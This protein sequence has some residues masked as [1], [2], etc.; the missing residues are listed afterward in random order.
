MKKDVG[1]ETTVNEVGKSTWQWIVGKMPF[2]GVVPLCTTTASH[3]KVN[4]AEVEGS[5]RH[6][7]CSSAVS[8][9]LFSVC[10]LWSLKPDSWVAFS[11]CFP[12]KHVPVIYLGKRT[13]LQLHL[14]SHVMGC[15]I[16]ASTELNF[17]P[18]HGVACIAAEEEE[19]ERWEDC[20]FCNI[21]S[22]F[23][24]ESVIQG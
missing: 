22:L 24:R 15:F 6:L 2:T 21:Y 11:V 18:A 14:F 1:S 7:R 4:A 16:C 17:F 3:W 10:L 19:E 8:S 12:P 9:V 23:Y 13:F 5:L 20:A